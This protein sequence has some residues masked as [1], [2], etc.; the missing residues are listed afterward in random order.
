[1]PASLLTFF[2]V[3]ASTRTTLM[4]NLGNISRA[5]NIPFGQKNLAIDASYSWD[6]FAY[7]M[8]SIS[9]FSHFLNEME[10]KLRCFIICMI[11]CVRDRNSFLLS[12]WCIPDSQ[13]RCLIY[14]GI[15]SSQAEKFLT[16]LMIED[17]HGKF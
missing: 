17:S 1:M 13:V 14:L 16:C 6:A 11:L 4:H 7:Y 12:V 9:Y 10:G 8:L 5:R 3:S 15:E 2:C